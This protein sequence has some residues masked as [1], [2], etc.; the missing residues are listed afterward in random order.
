MSEPVSAASATSLC[1]LGELAVRGGGN[2]GENCS[3]VD[4]D[5]C[6]SWCC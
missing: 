6:F 5:L 3:I 1:S 2:Q 4:I